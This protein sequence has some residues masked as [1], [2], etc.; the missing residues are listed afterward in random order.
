MLTLH[1]FFFSLLLVSRAPQGLEGRH[2][3]LPPTEVPLTDDTQIT[4]HLH[5]TIKLL[6]VPVGVTD[7]ECICIVPELTSKQN[8]RAEAW[9]CT[10]EAEAA[11]ACPRPLPP[12]SW[13]SSLC[14]GCAYRPP[15]PG[16]VAVES[17]LRYVQS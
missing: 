17:L 14:L 4:V 10:A 5:A 7:T 11:G 9:S 13:P 15:P 3:L 1:S 12:P 6:N 8:G 16:S 2:L